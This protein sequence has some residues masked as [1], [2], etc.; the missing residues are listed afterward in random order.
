MAAPALP[1]A[2]QLAALPVSSTAQEITVALL[3]LLKVNR[4]GT[5]AT[6]SFLALSIVIFSDFCHYLFLWRIDGNLQVCKGSWLCEISRACRSCRKI[7]DIFASWES[8]C[9]VR[10][11][12]DYE[13]ENFIFYIFP[14][15]AFLHSQG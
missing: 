2:R 11:P 15:C 4:F 10:V 1:A 12:L 9:S 7:S 3:R 8:K 5:L 14:M 13:L 6:A